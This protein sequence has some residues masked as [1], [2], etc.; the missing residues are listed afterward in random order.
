[1][2][3][4][5]IFDIQEVTDPAKMEEYRKNSH[6]TVEQYGGRYIVRGGEMEVAEGDWRPT[7][8]VVLEFPSLEQ[9]RT[10]YNSPEY[11]AIR[12]LRITGTRSDMV[13]VEG[14]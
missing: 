13:M 5:C 3:A 8:L 12:N 10:W 2:P 6:S 7:R 9:A 11:S 1:M 4:Y 14:T